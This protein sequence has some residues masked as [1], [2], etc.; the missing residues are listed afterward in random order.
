[1]V[2]LEM[3]RKDMEKRLQEDKNLRYVDIHADTLEDALADAAVQLETTVARLEYEVL[4]KGTAGFIGF[5][6]KPWTLRIYENAALAAEKKHK[7]KKESV[8]KSEAEEL[9]ENQ[10]KDGM[11]FVHYFSSEINLKVVPP[12]GNGQPVALKEVLSRLK[13][14]DTVSFD[15]EKIKRFVERGTDGVY[16]PIGQYT[17]NQAGDALVGVDISHDEMK[18]T[19]TVT[20]PAIGGADVSAEQVERLLE[21]QGVVAG[22]NRQAIDDFVDNPVY[23]I[24]YQVAG[25]VLPADGR[26]AYIEYHFET[27]RTKLRL[28]ETESGQV[29]F[30]ELNLVQNVVEGQLLAEKKLPERGKA[31]KTVTG[32]YLEAKNGRDMNLPL[33]KN[34]VVDES[35]LKILAAVN[36]QVLLINDKINVEPIMEVNGVSIKT[37]NIT[38]LG[39]VIVKGNV[40]DGFS[41]KASG[42]IEVYGTVGKSLLDAD[43]DIVVSQGVMGRDEGSIRCGK[44]LWAKF[45]QNTTVE[46]EDYIIVSDSIVNSNVVSN[47]KILVQG[48]RAAIIGGHL[49]ATEEIYAK[50]I[51]SAGGGSETVLEVGYDPRAKRRLNELTDKQ[52]ELVKELDEV[53]LNIQTLENTKKV[54]RT[55]PHDKEES[56]AAMTVRKNEIIEETDVILEEI[57][58]IQQHL[59][60]LKVIGKVS[61]SGTV[62]AGVKVYVRDEKDEVRTD[63]KSVTFFYEDGFV[64]RGKYE[65]PSEEDT[66]RVPDGYSAN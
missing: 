26:D 3:I 32:R 53:D 46:V 30:K 28:K 13:R 47:K 54:R 34:V 17:H 25:A 44:S 9:P 36:G 58:Q 49:F 40:D 4:E 5:L 61:A 12:A 10:D 8:S 45:I 56:L 55:L 11:F 19:I 57:E 64:R 41:V 35:G 31:G 42:N 62:Y 51:G 29:D 22:I 43:G 63:T 59:R 33:G 65:A 52:N 16:E 20:A 48:K 23:G 1:M 37:G 27:D 7:Q 15:E 14:S 38:F 2:T 39:T 6:K 21:T 50:N 18:A 60:E 24:P 66:K